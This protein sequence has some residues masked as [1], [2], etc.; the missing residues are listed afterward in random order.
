VGTMTPD[1]RRKMKDRAERSE[2]RSIRFEISYASI[3]TVVLTA[4]A[5]WL[6]IQLWAIVMVVIVALLL[7][8]TLNP[9]VGWLEKHG[10]KRVWAV[11]LA[12]IGV[13]VCVVL[14]GLLIVPPLWSQVSHIVENLPTI[15]TEVAKKLEAHRLTAPL[16]ETVR[17]FATGKTVEG[18]TVTS[19]VAISLSVV[20][21]LAYG[22][23]SIVLAIYFI[24]DHERMRGT[25]YALVPRRFHV[26]LARVL[27]NLEMIVGGYM[28]GQVV[29][30]IAIGMFAFALFSICRVPNALA[31]AA[32]ASLVDVIPFVGGILA[33]AP[34]VLAAASR[35]TVVATIVLVAMVFYQEFESR[36]VVP[37]VYGKTLRLPSAAVVVA[38]LIGGKLGGI[39]GALLALPL[40]AAVLMLVEELRLELPGDDT[41]DLALRAQDEQ[42]ERS[43]ARR[44]AGASPEEAGAIALDIEQIRNSESASG[45]E[46]PPK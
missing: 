45:H 11:A 14:L 3:A 10:V 20:G 26:R 31:L 22:A 4:L 2:G 8:G 43:Y 7:V 27:L 28:R 37:R 6:L 15:R 42:A 36:V 46:N 34:A 38:L 35:G 29:T 44:S 1:R 9:L 39:L 32:F 21:A 13:G 5:L 17:H 12:F 16:G 24:A 40:A 25:L 18:A 30:S 33:T 41:D 19:A 23:T